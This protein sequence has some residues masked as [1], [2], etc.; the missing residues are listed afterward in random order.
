M[1]TILV[2]GSS[3]GIGR[4]ISEKLLAQNHSVIGLARDHS[5]FAP[6]NVNYRTYSLD[7]AVISKL[8]ENFRRIQKEN[9]AIDTLVCSVGYG[10]F[11]ALEQFSVARMQRM[12]NVNFLSQV[13]L[14]KNFLPLFKQK[15]VGKIILLGSECALQGQKKG[16][17]YCATK[18]AL[19][20]FSQ[21]LRKE[22]A[23]ANI[24]VTLINPGIVATP[25]FT[26]LDF[27][28]ASGVD[29]AIQPDQIATLVA[30]LIHEEQNCVYEEIN[31][32]PVKKV[33]QAKI[34]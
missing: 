4:A 20:G 16:S 9:P 1:K 30:H 7:F 26:A 13:M 2:A 22:C 33:V 11:A 34:S 32:Q 8:E 14:V 27:E 5:K 28:P 21:S 19:R 24:A 3:S 23:A 18:F 17:I 31:L 15:K 29:H 12:L 25:F 10:E 6:T